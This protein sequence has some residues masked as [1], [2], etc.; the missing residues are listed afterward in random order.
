MIVELV[1]V[2]PVHNTISSV[3]EDRPSRDHYELVCEHVGI[4]D[5]SDLDTH[6]DIHVI[7]IVVD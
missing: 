5:R 4:V 6:N 2:T 3:R 7:L 1:S